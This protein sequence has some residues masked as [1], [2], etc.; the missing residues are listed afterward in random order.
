MKKTKLSLG[1]SIYNVF[2]MENVIDIYPLTGDPDNPGTYY[3]NPEI[4]NLPREGGQYSRSFYD[5]PWH[6]STPR[7]MNFF[8]R[9][10]FN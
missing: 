6:Y 4:E 10:D 3:R 7:E 5:R 9:F 8:V 2:D 1:L